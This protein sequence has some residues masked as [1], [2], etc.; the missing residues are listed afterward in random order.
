MS[1]YR[2]FCLLNH[3]RPH[4]TCVHLRFERVMGLWHAM[5]LSLLVSALRAR[6]RLQNRGF[7]KH[8]RHESHA[9][10]RAV[11]CWQAQKSNPGGIFSWPK[12]VQV[13]Y[14]ASIRAYAQAR[15]YSPTQP[16]QRHPAQPNPPLNGRP[17]GVPPSLG[18]SRL[19]A[20]FLWPR[21]GVTPLASPLALR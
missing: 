7:A 1:T 8:V 21:L 2:H 3:V 12:P 9:S 20:H 6:A 5:L 13:V 16:G 14:F 15:E 10:V 11:V 17:N 19:F 18:H 4:R